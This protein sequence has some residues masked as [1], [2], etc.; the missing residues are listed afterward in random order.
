MVATFTFL[1][2]INACLV[3]SKKILASFQS[4]Y[5]KK[6]ILNYFA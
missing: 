1:N 3:E 2:I 4:F 5:I 6:I